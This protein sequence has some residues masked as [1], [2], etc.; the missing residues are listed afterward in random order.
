RGAEDLADLR[1]AEDG[2]LVLRLEHALE[3]SLDLFDRLVYDRVVAALYALL[4]CHL[5]R[6]ALRADVEADDDG[7][8]GGGQVDV[9]L[10]DRTDTAV[11]DPDADLIA[12]VDLRQR[13]LERLDRTGHVAL[14]D[15]VELLA[16]AL[17]HGGHEVLE[18]T[19]HPALGL[20][21]G[22]LARLPLL[23]IS[24]E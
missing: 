23:G 14:E 15:E 21:G 4:L 22:T 10:G 11:D 12:D 19:A 1:L 6:L 13:V 16:L 24:E 2:L 8:G 7:V 17:L 20:Q 3:C 5:R 9:G 18:G